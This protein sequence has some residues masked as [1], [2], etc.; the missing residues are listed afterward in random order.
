MRLGLFCA[1]SRD[2][3]GTGTGPV[4]TRRAAAHPGVR[5]ECGGRSRGSEAGEHS[6]AVR[7]F[8]ARTIAAVCDRNGRM[9]ARSASPYLTMTVLSAGYRMWSG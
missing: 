3:P 2:R 8:H 5:R 6:A 4:Q 7:C 1:V 9:G